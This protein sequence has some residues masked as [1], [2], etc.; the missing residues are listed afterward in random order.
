MKRYALISVSDKT[1]IELLA[2][3]LIASGFEIISTGGTAK[4]LIASGLAVHRVSDLT[5]F[6]EIM[7][8]RVKTLHPNIH[9]GIL[10]ERDNPE[11]I[12][13]ME[14]NKIEP[15]DIVAVNLYPFEQTLANPDSTH[16]DIIENIDIGGPTLVRAA[17]KNCRFVTVL[18]DPADYQKVIGEIGR[19]GNTSEQTRLQLAAIAFQHIELYDRAI[20][21]YFNEVTRNK[22]TDANDEVIATPA[23]INLSL[24]LLQTMRYG[25]NPHQQAGLYASQTAGW[26]VIHGKPM[27]YNN[28]LDF[29]AAL[30]GITLFV[31][32]SVIIFKHTN[33]CGIGSGNNLVEAYI[34]ALQTDTQSPYGGI[35]ITNRQ[36][37]IS[38]A[39][40][41]N[42]IFTEIIIAP[43]FTPEALSLLMKKKDRRLV[44]YNLPELMAHRPQYELKTMTFGYLLQDWDDAIQSETGW[45]VVTDRQPSEYEGRALR[46]AWR[47]VAI[48]KSN[49]IA[50]S[51]DCA[52]VGL[53]SGQTSR[54]DSAHIAINR[55]LQYGHDLAG[56]VC[57]SDGFFPFPDSVELLNQYGIRA[58][59]QPGGSK[60]DEA[61]IQACNRFGISM[62]LT[63]NRHFRH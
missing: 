46:F 59:I 54:V 55:A 32:P 31:S 8:G 44:T 16:S 37:D 58:I 21:M 5:G 1:G 12:R 51:T 13:Q 22:E 35:V 10:A 11:H 43:E 28:M 48:L 53:G 47:S 36:V 42:E 50:L 52:T 25:E 39:Q 14:L 7:D 20:S 2:Q 4:H 63:G 61:V 17:A 6:P 40:H 45:Q 9:G 24:S 56:A 18:T 38:E 60:G 23:H 3:A 26:Q 15:I 49:G 27:S 57:A 33:P 19:D 30:K 34:R 41:I 62:I 29:D